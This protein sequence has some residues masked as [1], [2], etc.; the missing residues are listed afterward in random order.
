MWWTWNLLEFGTLA[1]I[2]GTLSLRLLKTVDYL[3]SDD[4]KRVEVRMLA[5]RLTL[6]LALRLLKT[7]DSLFSDGNYNVEVRILV[8]RVRGEAGRCRQSFFDL[9]MLA[10]DIPTKESLN[11]GNMSSSS[12]KVL[13]SGERIS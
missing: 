13:Y 7:V 4:N 10:H 11:A 2:S 1:L 12:A 3:F 9:N 8:L 6:R 5:L